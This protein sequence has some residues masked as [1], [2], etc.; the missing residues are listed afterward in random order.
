MNEPFE[1]PNE[2]VEFIQKLSNDELVS[3]TGD[4][5]QCSKDVN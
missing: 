2:F 1:C 5:K 3:L 4:L